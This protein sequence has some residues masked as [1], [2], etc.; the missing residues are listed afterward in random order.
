MQGLKFCNLQ[1]ADTFSLSN[2]LKNDLSVVAIHRQG[3]FV[4]YS[5]HLNIYTYYVNA[6]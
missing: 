5:Y 1:F 2:S 3:Y 6:G 4:I